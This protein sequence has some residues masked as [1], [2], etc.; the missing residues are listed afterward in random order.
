[1]KALEVTGKI[2]E[3]QFHSLLILTIRFSRAF[4]SV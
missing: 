4:L 2:H 1:M 3:G